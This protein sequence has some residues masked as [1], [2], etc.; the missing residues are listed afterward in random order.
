MNRLRLLLWIARIQR[1]NPRALRQLDQMNAM[2]AGATAA[3]A[4]ITA[5]WIIRPAVLVLYAYLGYG[6]R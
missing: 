3:L 6:W 2:L 4:I 1:G 5:I